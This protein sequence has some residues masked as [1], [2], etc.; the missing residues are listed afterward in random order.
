[1]I[2]HAPRILL[3]QRQLDAVTTPIGSHI[4]LYTIHLRLAN[5]HSRKVG[6]I[7]NGTLGGGFEVNQSRVSVEI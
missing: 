3:D 4:G 1:M 6:V 2:C 5:I 7:A